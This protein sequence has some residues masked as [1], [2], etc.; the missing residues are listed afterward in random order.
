MLS[1]CRVRVP[2]GCPLHAPEAPEAQGSRPRGRTRVD[3]CAARVPAPSVP[4]PRAAYLAARGAGEC[5]RCARPI[6][7]VPGPRR[8]CGG[9]ERAQ[10]R[11]PRAARGGE[12]VDGQPAHACVGEQPVRRHW[13]QARPPALLR[14]A[15]AGASAGRPPASARRGGGRCMM[16]PCL[17][18]SAGVLPGWPDP[19]GYLDRLSALRDLALGDLAKNQRKGHLAGP[20]TSP[21]RAHQVHAEEVHDGQARH[22][23]Q[24][25]RQARRTP[26]VPLRTLSSSSW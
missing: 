8:R 26:M 2:A 10:G 9:L 25:G 19:A 14:P 21:S 11:P 17:G 3:T 6:P 13:G 18:R 23:G 20:A 1:T 5:T 4:T 16:A 22:G 15:S 24:A 12:P 7:M